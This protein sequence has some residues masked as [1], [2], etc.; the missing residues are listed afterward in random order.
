MLSNLNNY[1]NNNKIKNIPHP[2]IIK[3][4]NNNNYDYWFDEVL[5]KVQK[6]NK[7]KSRKYSN[8][9]IFICFRFN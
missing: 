3:D 4:N 5:S 9:K 8:K 2:V 1:N 6:L 7:P